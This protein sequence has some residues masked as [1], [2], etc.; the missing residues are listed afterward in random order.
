MRDRS[1]KQGA[2]VRIEFDRKAAPLGMELTEPGAITGELARVARVLPPE[3]RLGEDYNATAYL[4][5][6]VIA[7]ASGVSTTAL[8]ALVKEAVQRL[9]DRRRAKVSVN[10]LSTA[11]GDETVR[12]GVR[13]DTD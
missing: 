1:L 4:I 7:T 10:E 13:E 11:P 12:L 2:V 5:E 3:R 9:A 6:F 8:V